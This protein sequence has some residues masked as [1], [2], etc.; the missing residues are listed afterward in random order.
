MIPRFLRGVEESVIALLL[1]A[2][3]LLV[4]L[5]VILRYGFSSGFLWIQELTLLLAAWLV[6]LGA[7]YGVKK[8]AHI[9]MDMAVR[10]L[11]PRWRRAAGML[12]VLL[13]LLYCALFIAGSWQYLAKIKQFGIELEDLPLPQWLAHGVL[14]LGFALLVFRFL[15]VGWKIL[16][17]RAE[18]VLLADEASEA[19][20]D[21]RKGPP[22]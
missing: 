13:C 6:L 19:V 21:S 7:A 14:L 17:R 12:A 18:G 9:G 22:A 20:K 3:T 5:E 11:P 15:E 10:R 2:M 8:G 16:G 4:T 1:V